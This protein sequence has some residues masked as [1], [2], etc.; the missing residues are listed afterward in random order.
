MIYIWR[1]LKQ[2]S[3]ITQNLYEFQQFFLCDFLNQN[4]PIPPSPRIP[5]GASC[6]NA[7][8][9]YTTNSVKKI[10]DHAV[11]K[12][13]TDALKYGSKRAIQKP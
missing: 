11:S 2:F 10:F 12:F 1:Y 6:A 9:F 7:L 3:T 4:V 8:K 5:Q 13:A